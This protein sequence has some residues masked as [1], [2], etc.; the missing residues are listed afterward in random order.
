MK[1]IITLMRTG[2]TL[3]ETLRLLRGGIVKDEYGLEFRYDFRLEFRDTTD[4]GSQWWRWRPTM[5]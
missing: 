4:T 2:F 5:I 1:K 3:I